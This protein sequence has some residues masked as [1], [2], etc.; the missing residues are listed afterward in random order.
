MS[1]IIQLDLQHPHLAAKLTLP[2]CGISAIIGVSGSGKTTLLRAIAGLESAAVGLVEINGDVWQDDARRFR[3]PT[4][5]RPVGFVFQEASLFPHLSVQANLDFGLRRSRQQAISLPKIT[6]LLGIGSL[7]QRSTMTLSGGEK[8]RVGIARALAS[9]P[10]LM[11][12]DEPLAS[13]DEQRKAEILPYLERLTTELSLPILYVSH[14]IS[15]VAQMADYV[16]LLDAGKVR[17]DGG[18]FEVLSRSDLPYAHGDHAFALVVARRVNYD[19]QYQLSQFDFSG[20]SIFLPQS[21]ESIA[22]VGN[23]VRLRIQARDIS[24]SLAPQ[25]G[26]S[27]L[28]SIRVTIQTITQDSAGLFMLELDAGGTRLLAR[29]TQKSLA[30]L[31]LQVGTSVHAQIKGVAILC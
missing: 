22:P 6:E 4:H 14:S 7:L 8:Q 19:A 12:M 1:E 23:E 2:G 21:Q 11:L 18:V 10:K 24:L 30:Q 16:V 31:N 5:R 13:L 9:S 20:G 17:A 29:I 28:N 25:L 15:E 27:I 3:L 26:S